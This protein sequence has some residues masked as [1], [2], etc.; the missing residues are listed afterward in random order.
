MKHFS[1]MALIKPNGKSLIL[2]LLPDK[3]SGSFFKKH[4]S[5]QQMR[6]EAFTFFYLPTT[7]DCSH[8]TNQFRENVSLHAIDCPY[9]DFRRYSETEEDFIATDL[10]S[11]DLEKRT[12]AADI[13]RTFFKDAAEV[14]NL[15]IIKNANLL[16]TIQHDNR[17]VPELVALWY[18]SILY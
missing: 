16:T 6:Q 12:K 10:E 4:H 3:F 9:E 17:F 11:K 14:S 18:L 7:T 15:N 13:V 2:K 5:K 1:P 8:N